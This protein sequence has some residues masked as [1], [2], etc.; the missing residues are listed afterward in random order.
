MAD[1]FST[2]KYGVAIGV[3]IAIGALGV[4]LVKRDKTTVRGFATDVLSH[5]LDFKEKAATFMEGAKEAVSDMVAEAQAKQ[6]E[7]AESE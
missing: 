4:M 5:G 2:M 1:K 7:R 6:K 3:G